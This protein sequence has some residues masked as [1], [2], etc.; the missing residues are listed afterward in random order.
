MTSTQILERL[1]IASPLSDSESCSI[2]DGLFSEEFDEAVKGAILGM[3]RLRGVQAAE[4]ASFAKY[5]RTH[6]PSANVAIENVIDTCGTGGGSPSF[7]ISTAAALMAAAAGAKVAKHGN[8]AV[9]SK[10][11]SADVLEA[12]GVVIQSD[13]SLLLDQIQQL[14][15]A[16]LFAPAH[17][18]AMKNV[19]PARKSLGIKTV[20][21]QLGPLANPFGAKRQ[22]MGVYSQDLVHPMAEALAILG[23]E[24]AV[25]V[26]SRDGLDEISPCAPTISAWVENGKVK[27][28]WLEPS[29]F[30]L[31]TLD[32]SAISPGNSVME[33]ASILMEAISDPNSPRCGACL[34]NAGAALLIAGLVDSLK[35]GAEL[36]H[37][38][39][40]D[41]LAKKKL[42]ELALASN[43]SIR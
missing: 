12:N 39:V 29:T 2:M 30:G 9:T 20:F 42:E 34:P 11:G 41:G 4:L 21:N 33:G 23:T 27:L 37:Q 13:P 8:R 16:F 25:V 6:T 10:C 38:T 14:G 31:P 35:Q 43:S 17:H 36:A 32:E 5:L 26:H 7:N 19:G 1:L 3:L 15:I 24:H 40:A 18:P 28:R 22:L